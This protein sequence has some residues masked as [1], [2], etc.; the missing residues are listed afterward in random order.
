MAPIKVMAWLCSVSIIA[1]VGCEQPA[2][3]LVPVEGI[4]TLEGQPLPG[5]LIE[6]LPDAFRGTSGPRSSATSDIDGRFKL[7]CDNQKPGAV[8]GTHR[9][10]VTDPERKPAPQGG[11]EGPTPGRISFLYQDGDTT[12]LVIQVPAKG[13]EVK[14]GLVKTPQPGQ[15]PRREGGGGD[16]RPG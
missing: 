3:K 1:V 16:I 2:A 14:L 15:P 11:Q 12:P 8:P 13:G 7:L 9:V 5:V 6:F 4:V 10:L